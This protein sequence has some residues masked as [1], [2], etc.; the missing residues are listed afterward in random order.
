LD[1]RLSR[2]SEIDKY[3][4][5]ES[6]LMRILDW[7]RSFLG[8]PHPDLGR[9]GAVCPFILPS[10][11]SDNIWLVEFTEDL[12]FEKICRMI[13]YYGELFLRTEP[14]AMPKAINKAFVI[15]LS[16]IKEEDTEL[17]DQVQLNLKEH[18]INQ[19]LMLGEFHSSND[20]S[21]L[22][23]E[24]FRPLRS[25]IPMLAIRHMTETDLPFLIGKHYSPIQ[26]KNF[27][28]AYLKHVRKNVSSQRFEQAMRV[29]LDAEAQIT[30][31]ITTSE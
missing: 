31:T 22:R 2:A 21:G 13:R 15:V 25:P 29:M 8:K 23:N 27:S 28:F 19:G 14:V 12:N 3:H 10:I 4:S 9:K 7:T 24:S 26:R 30:R 1:L 6:S 5:N 18:F 11:A 16:S 17:V 20:T